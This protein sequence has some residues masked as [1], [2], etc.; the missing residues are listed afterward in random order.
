MN[1]MMKD[2][3]GVSLLTPIDRIHFLVVSFGKVVETPLFA[4][5]RTEQITWRGRGKM[6]KAYRD[7][8]LTIRA[9]VTD[10]PLARD[11]SGDNEY[12]AEEGGMFAE[13]SGESS[14]G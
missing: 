4:R 12:D 9:Y 2:G 7:P 14:E 5:C 8:K 13:A 11:D 1:I 6:K 3:R 10:S